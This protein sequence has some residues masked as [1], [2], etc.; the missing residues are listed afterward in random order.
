[1][2]PTWCRDGSGFVFTM[3]ITENSGYYTS[4]DI[5]IYR[6]SNGSTLPLTQLYNENVRNIAVS[7]DGR[8]AAFERIMMN[9]ASGTDFRSVQQLWVMQLNNP[10]STW[11]VAVKG[12]P[13]QPTRSTRVP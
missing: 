3:G 5:M 6:F 13:G 11:P 12:N 10:A 7:S 4:R 1:M 2:S 9:S 8:F